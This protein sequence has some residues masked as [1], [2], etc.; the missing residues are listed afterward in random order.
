MRTSQYPKFDRSQNRGSSRTFSRIYPSVE[1]TPI[2]STMF[3][4]IIAN[5]Y[6]YSK[7]STIHG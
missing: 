6:K 2:I 7:A 1:L 4:A 5:N 3:T